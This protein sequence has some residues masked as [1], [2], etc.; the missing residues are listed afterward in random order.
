MKRVNTILIIILLMM[1][2]CGGNRQS[3][4]PF[5][6]IDVRASYPKKNLIL[7]DFMDVRYVALET[8]GEFLCQGRVLDIGKDV[9][10]VRNDSQDGDIFV[11]DGNGRGIR[12]CYTLKNKRSFK[13]W[14]RIYTLGMRSEKS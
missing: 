14:E 3:G 4:D 12:N 11:F 13:S 1:E 2:G 6:I 9:I 10:L 5:I 7:Q 8:S